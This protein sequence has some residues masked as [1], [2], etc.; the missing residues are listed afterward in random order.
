MAFRRASYMLTAPTMPVFAIAVVVAALSALVRYKV[1]SIAA[2]NPHT[3]EM[4][5]I[6]VVLL[7][8]GVLLRGL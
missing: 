2:L 3:Y 1:V 8:A 5:L 6:S 4:M 7:V